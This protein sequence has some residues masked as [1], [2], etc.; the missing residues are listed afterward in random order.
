MAGSRPGAFVGRTGEIALCR[1]VLS[2][3]L[4]GRGRALLID[5]EPGIGKSALLTVLLRMAKSCGCTVLPGHADDLSQQFPMRVL[6]DC[7]GDRSASVGARQ[8]EPSAP[9]SAAAPGGQEADRPG[10]LLDRVIRLVTDR[11]A[12]GP[13]VLAI[14][15]LHWADDDSLLAWRR[16]SEMAPDLPLLLAG[17][18]CPVP[19]RPELAGLR[20]Q[21]SA[22]GQ[23]VT[24]LGPLAH[25]EVTELVAV[26]AGG[27]PTARLRR[28]T[29]RAGGNPLYITELVDALLR[30]DRL[31]VAGG[32]ADF[33]T[34]QQ[35]QA[36]A[37]AISDRLSFLSAETSRMLRSASLLGRDFTPAEVA[38]VASLTPEQ[39]AVTLGEARAA[40]VVAEADGRL[41]FRYLLIR[42]ALYE[43]MP[44]ALRVALHRQAAQALAEAGATDERVAEQLLATAQTATNS[45]A[46][47][48]LA[49]ATPRLVQRVP[50]MAAELL[51]REMSGA[52]PDDPRRDL[53]AGALAAALLRLGRHHEAVDVARPLLARTRDEDRRAD[54]V[55]VLSH[56]LLGCDRAEEALDL[57][58]DTIADPALSPRW[59]ARL[60][61]LAALIHLLSGRL[62]DADVTARWA[63]AEGQH[64]GD[65]YAASHA[66]HILALV[67]THSSAHGAVY[68]L[69]T[70]GLA[71]L[72]ALGDEPDAAD[73]RCSLLLSRMAA[74][75]QLGRMAEAGIDLRAA[76][77]VAGP[78]NIPVPLVHAAAEYYLRIGRWDDALDQL[79]S[80]AGPPGEPDGAGHDPLGRGIS[81]LIAGH[82]D[83]RATAAAHRQAARSGPRSAT[84]VTPP[85]DAAYLIL[86][87]ALAAERDGQLHQAAADLRPALDRDDPV[88]SR[89][90]SLGLPA[91]V[92]LGTEIGDADLAAAAAAVSEQAARQEGTAITAAVAEHCQGLLTRQPALL[93]SAAQTY[94]D[95]GIPLEHAQ[96]EEDA[97]ELLAAAHEPVQARHALTRATD[98]FADLGADWDIRRADTRLRR[99]GIRRGRGRSRSSALGWDS[100]TPAEA[101]IAQLISLGRSTPDIAQDLLLSPRTVQT[102]ISHILRKLNGRSRVDIVRASVAGGATPEDPTLYR[103]AAVPRDFG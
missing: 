48:W 58:E 83:D 40:R 13:L 95:I 53:L 41:N 96:A 26:L 31:E 80:T 101:K 38:A 68:Q 33:V 63:L 17:T 25:D 42:Q 7:L 71:V 66:L 14:D 49:Q 21:L 37:I 56:A 78:W 94:R 36:V 9:S 60:R 72:G 2:Q 1:E 92:R 86:A 74:L 70:Q 67:R 6:L 4:Q 19:Y 20:Q 34:G 103:G 52:S 76:Q 55:R 90:R 77:D 24:S 61:A 73:L 50:E 99:Y 32:T 46:R 30:S 84:G 5:G 69:T 85:G 22:G 87:G 44:R 82:R 51:R 39:L 27:E 97:A 15:D 11:C 10:T 64:A 93:L 89:L 8:A 16:L 57:A 98:S 91:L 18:F 35:P 79:A 43:S 88:S 3:V 28:L 75:Q 29:E 102:H 59:R 23:V 47:D 12:Q 65:S 100:L 54:I 45:W 62:H 81:A